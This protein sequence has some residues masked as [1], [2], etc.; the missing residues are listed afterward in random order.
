MAR[1]IVPV[2]ITNH[3]AWCCGCAGNKE[4]NDPARIVG[5]EEG[6]QISLEACFRIGIQVRISHNQL[7]R[8]EIN[9]IGIGRWDQ[10]HYARLHSFAHD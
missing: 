5:Q 2:W 4:G 7:L 9:Q 1:H 8:G 6:H 10:L 3:R